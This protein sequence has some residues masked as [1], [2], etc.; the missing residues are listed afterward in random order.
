MAVQ[1]S[2][3]VAEV[4]E[5]IISKLRSVGY[6]ESTIGLQSRELKRLGRWCDQRGGGFYTKELGA[7]FAAATVQTRTN[8]QRRRHIA[9]KTRF[10]PLAAG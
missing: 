4:I 2:M 7:L 1:A 6:A 9:P 8:R 5:A 3:P 10:A